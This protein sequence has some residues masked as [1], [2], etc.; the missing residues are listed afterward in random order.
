MRGFPPPRT[1]NARYLWFETSSVI[2]P[3][4]V[5]RGY[6]LDFSHSSIECLQAMDLVPEPCVS[7]TDATLEICVYRE[8]HVAPELGKR[9]LCG[10]WLFEGEVGG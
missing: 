3:N 4:N 7:S 8:S 9:L 5:V 2:S 10:G 6:T 1:R